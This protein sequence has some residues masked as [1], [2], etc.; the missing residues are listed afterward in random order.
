VKCSNKRLLLTE[1]GDLV[2]PVVAVETSGAW[3]RL[4]ITR[5]GQTIWPKAHSETVANQDLE[6]RG[7]VATNSAAECL[8]RAHE[9]RA[10]NLRALAAVFVTWINAACRRQSRGWAPARRTSRPSR[11]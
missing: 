3:Q 5:T 10:T 6:T 8:E 1:A 2:E 11:S 4:M 9:R 7:R